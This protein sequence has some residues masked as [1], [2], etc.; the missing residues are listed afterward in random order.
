VSRPPPA[1][2]SR[3]NT[4][5]APR[6]PMITIRLPRPE[7]DEADAQHRLISRVR[8]LIRAEAG[9]TAAVDFA[10]RAHACRGHDDLIALIRDTV[11]VLP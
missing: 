1:P 5:R 2:P 3:R 11:T 7:H 4:V 8:H 9:R 6:H 10:T